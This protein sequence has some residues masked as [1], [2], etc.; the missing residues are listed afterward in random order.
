[1]ESVWNT[2]VWIGLSRSNNSTPGTFTWSDKTQVTWTNWAVENPRG[3]WTGDNC[4][5]MN[6]QRTTKDLMYW[7]VGN[8]NKEKLFICKKIISK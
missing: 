2:D 8:C 4:V 1:M 7:K 5:Y 6:L 3:S